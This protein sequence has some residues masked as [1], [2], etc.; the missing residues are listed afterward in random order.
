MILL[1]RHPKVLLAV[2]TLAGHPAGKGPTM[3]GTPYCS[4]V[5]TKPRYPQGKGPIAMGISSSSD[6]T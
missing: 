1:R 3:A 2:S 5:L 6:V 4:K